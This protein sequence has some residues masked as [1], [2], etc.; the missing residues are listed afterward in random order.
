MKTGSHVGERWSTRTL[1]LS[2]ILGAISIVLGA[3][4]LGFI[5]VP[6]AAGSA[7]IMHIPAILAGTL[8]G[9]LAGAL[10]G[11]IFG[12]HSFMRA[13]APFFADPIIALLPR[14]LIGIVA[15]SIYRIT[16]SDAIAAAFGTLTNTLGVMCLATVKGYIT[17]PVACG[18]IVTH[19]VPEVIVAVILTTILTK[20]I[21][22]FRR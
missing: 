17:W 3:T 20:A 14:I 8:E 16:K 19:G 6:T 2:G 7:T 4:P 5:P 22:K 11:L 1:T 9:P 18:I 15:S 12:L 13:G 21:R 10:T